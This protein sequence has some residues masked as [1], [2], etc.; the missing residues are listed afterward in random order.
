MYC[1]T[2]HFCRNKLFAF[3]N[4]RPD[5]RSLIPI[6]AKRDMVAYLGMEAIPPN[7]IKRIE[8]PVYL[9]YVAEG[10]AKKKAFLL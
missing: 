5:C 8:K 9:K 3:L 4:S 7:W 6:S 2:F 10:L 1:F